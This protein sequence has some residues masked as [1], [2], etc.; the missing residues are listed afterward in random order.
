MVIL[1]IT[2]CNL[3]GVCLSFNIVYNNYSF[4]INSKVILYLS[5]SFLI[6]TLAAAYLSLVERQIIAITQHRIGPSKIF[7]FG[8][9]QPIADAL[10]LLL[11]YSFVPKYGNKQVIVF[12]PILSFVTAQLFIQLLPI[13]LFYFYITYY[14]C[15]Y[16][17]LLLVNSGWNIWILAKNFQN[18]IIMLSNLRFLLLTF[19]FSISTTIIFIIPCF[20][21]STYNLEH[22]ATFTSAFG[23]PLFLLLLPNSLVF[24]ITILTEI[25]KKCHLILPNPKLN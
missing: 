6:Y 25:K 24:W 4:A 11:K 10:K 21:Y 7:F 8:L 20:I 16:I 13:F 9:L 17:L 18:K 3:F 23:L 2:C 22:L 14:S 19:S 1:F 12:S 5:F 15:L